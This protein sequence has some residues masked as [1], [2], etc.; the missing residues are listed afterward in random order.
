MTR[1]R[2]IDS[3]SRKAWPT[4]PRANAIPLLSWTTG[5][6]VTSKAEG[7]RRGTFNARVINKDNARYLCRQITRYII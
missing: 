5:L 3:E 4:C 7:L 1:A 6:I 2:K